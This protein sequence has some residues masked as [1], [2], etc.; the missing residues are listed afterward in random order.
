MNTA[1]IVLI[2]IICLILFFVL[3]S[4]IWMMYVAY[5]IRNKAQEFIE[6]RGIDMLDKGIKN[7]SKKFDK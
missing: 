2:V 3:I 4:Y 7:A 5:K 6:N 1:I